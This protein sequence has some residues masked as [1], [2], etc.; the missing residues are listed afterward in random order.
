VAGGEYDCGQGLAQLSSIMPA[1][2]ESALP[3]ESHR[4]QDFER[5]VMVDVRLGAGAL[6]I[7]TGDEMHGQEIEI[8]PADQDAERAHTDVLRRKTAAGRRR[9]QPLNCPRS[10]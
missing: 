6:V 8:S 4:E 1:K 9:A 5:G 2:L 3:S 7:Y 10:A